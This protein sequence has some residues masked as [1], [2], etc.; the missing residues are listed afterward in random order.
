MRPSSLDTKLSL[1]EIDFYKRIINEF[2]PILVFNLLKIK[3]KLYKI[4][5]LLS[6]SPLF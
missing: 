2:E 3:V 6:T 4:Y 5:N 1:F